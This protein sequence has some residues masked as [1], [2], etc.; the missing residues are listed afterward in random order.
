MTESPHC[1]LKNTRA[2]RVAEQE[3]RQKTRSCKNCQQSGREEKNLS[4]QIRFDLMLTPMSRYRG[5]GLQ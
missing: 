5:I 1:F 3:V 2:K 4:T